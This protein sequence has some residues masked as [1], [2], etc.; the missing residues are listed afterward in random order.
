MVKRLVLHDLSEEDAAAYLQ[1]ESEEATYFPAPP[2]V[3]TCIGC[4]GCWTKTPGVCVVNDGVS[5]FAKMIPEHDVLVVISRCVYGSLSPEVKAVLERSVGVV[6]PFFGVVHGE[7]HHLK[8]YETMPELAYHFY[9][10]DLTE[11]EKDTA[12]LLTAANAVNL[13]APKHETYFYSSLSEAKGIL[14]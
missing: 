6:S 2:V 5:A 3:Q 8:R 13:Y 14:P 12:R 9:G 4:Y 7:M 1:G 10:P 11:R